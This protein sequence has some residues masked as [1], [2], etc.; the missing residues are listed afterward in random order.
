MHSLLAAL[1]LAC[2]SGAS[3]G[4]R[5][6][7]AVD[8]CDRG[9]AQACLEQGSAAYRGVGRER[10]LDDA[11]R[12]WARA[13]DGGLAQACMD[14]GILNSGHAHLPGGVHRH[15]DL[16]RTAVWYGLACDLGEP[17]GCFGL[18]M[19]HSEGGGLALDV[20]RARDLSAR[21]CGLGHQ[22]ACSRR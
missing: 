10:D 20:A 13:C 17:A 11:E 19:L 12:L 9:D 8:S 3:D 6:G 2:G 18:A 21:A 15:P 1:L 5:S 22:V 4:P 7:V 14:A 16:A